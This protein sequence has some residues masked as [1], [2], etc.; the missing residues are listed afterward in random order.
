MLSLSKFMVYVQIILFS[1]TGHSIL[2]Y[3]PF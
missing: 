1:L 2:A 3:Y